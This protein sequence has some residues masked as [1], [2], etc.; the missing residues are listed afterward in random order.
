VDEPFSGAISAGKNTYVYDAHTYHTNVPPQGIAKLIEYY[1]DSGGDVLDPFYGS[2]MTGV[3]A[4]EHGRK[5]LLSDLSPAAV[6]IAKNLNEPVDAGAYMKAVRTLLDQAAELE[7][8]L[9][10]TYCRICGE[11][12][13]M[14]YMV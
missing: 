4:G 7:H 11:P 8:T 1:T 12:V 3:A 9:Y 6:F 10:D 2:G 13:P 14:I 5:A